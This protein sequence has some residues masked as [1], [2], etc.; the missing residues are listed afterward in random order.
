MRSPVNKQER[1]LSGILL[2]LRTSMLKCFWMSCDGEDQNQEPPCFKETCLTKW[3]RMRVFCFVLSSIPSSATL[4][5]VCKEKYNLTT[6]KVPVGAFVSSAVGGHRVWLSLAAPSVHPFVLGCRNEKCE[7][8]C[9]FRRENLAGYQAHDV[10]FFVC[11]YYSNLNHC[12]YYHCKKF[13]LQPKHVTCCFK[14]FDWATQD[15]TMSTF[16]VACY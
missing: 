5:A 16:P 1:W 13:V 14:P 8:V 10:Q 7:A 2:E 12:S 15:L 4:A 6:K 3:S 9:Q 11:V